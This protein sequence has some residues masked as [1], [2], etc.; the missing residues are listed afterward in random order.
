VDRKAVLFV[1]DSAEC[2]KSIKFLRQARID[3]VEYNLTHQQELGCCGEPFVTE[4]PTIFAPE[5]IFR[6]LGGIKKYTK[7]MKNRKPLEASK[8]AWW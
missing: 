4:V 1:D 8:S 6:G 5:G 7:M 3:F 2:R